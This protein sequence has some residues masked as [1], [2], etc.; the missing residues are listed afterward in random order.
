[1]SKI[2]SRE[3]WR[4]NAKKAFRR[5]RFRVRFALTNPATRPRLTPLFICG[6]SGSGTSLLSLL[7]DERYAI[8]GVADESAL[9]VPRRSSPLAIWGMDRYPSIDA[10][11]EAL[12]I[13][14]GTDVA[15]IERDLRTF[16]H[17]RNPEARGG[18][19]VDKAPNAHLARA[20]WLRAAFPDAWFLL[21]VRHPLDA[22]EGLVRK[23]KLFRQAGIGQAC[24]FWTTM[25]NSFMDDSDQFR[26]R[27]ILVTYE[28]LVSSTDEALERIA[29][30]P[31]IPLRPEPKVRG[32]KGN[33]PGFG[34][35]NIVDGKIKIVRQPRPSLGHGLTDD[36]RRLIEI[37]AQPLYQEIIRQF[38]G[39]NGG[40]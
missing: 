3:F 12:Q 16:H 25:H 31:G 10:Y 22:I 2:F 11:V 26:D 13:P 39:R 6:V 29:E 7:L 35:R 21:L 20:G 36:A 14:P 5:A 33:R 24:K 15:R 28:S 18:F 17:A 32:S 40:R 37:E 1:M 23:W 4:I 27:V 19:V 9:G 30:R 34:I 38:S 8:A